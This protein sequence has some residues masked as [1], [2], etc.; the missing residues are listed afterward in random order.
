MN[1]EQTL[2][3]VIDTRTRSL[4]F[5]PLQ[6]GGIGG[7]GGGGGGPP[8]G[9]SGVLPQKRVAYDTDE[10]GTD[11]IPESGRSLYDNLN[12][13]RNRIGILEASGGGGGVSE[14]TSLVDVPNSYTGQAGKAAI[15]NATETGLEFGTV[16]SSGGGSGTYNLDLQDLTAQVDGSTDHFTFTPST[17]AIIVVINGEI[18][19]PEDVTLDIDCLGFTLDYIPEVTD[20][21]MILRTTFPN[22]TG[23]SG[24]YRQWLYTT[25]SGNLNIL[26]DSEGNPLTGLCDLE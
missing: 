14:F 9:F 4:L 26:T 8:G 16:V 25:I 2:I 11:F 20:N 22:G 24:R 19:K 6:L 10:F 3:Q 1:Y 21:L 5:R 7:S 12:H 15:V 13:I 18:V 23:N 17:T